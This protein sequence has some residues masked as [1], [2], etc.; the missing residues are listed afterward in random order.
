MN[1]GQD[2]LQRGKQHLNEIYFFLPSDQNTQ[3]RKKS[4]G[5]WLHRAKTA[6]S[7]IN[8]LTIYPKAKAKL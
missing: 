8:G 6:A 2:K 7:F 5:I 3:F 1:R 4:K